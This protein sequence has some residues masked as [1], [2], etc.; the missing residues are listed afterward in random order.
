MSGTYYQLGMTA[1]DHGRLEEAEDWYRK[2]LAITEEIGDRPGMAR[3]YAQLGRLAEDRGHTPQAL[4]W[5]IRCVTLF[6]EFPSSLT[7]TGPSALVRLTRQ[8]GLPALEDTWQ[9]VTGRPLPQQVR[10]YVTNQP[11]DEEDQP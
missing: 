9:Q 11:D 10:D 4:T 6:N 2:S 7:A 8:L 3:T 1:Y 5:N